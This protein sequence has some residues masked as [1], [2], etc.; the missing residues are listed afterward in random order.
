M[1]HHHAHRKFNREKA[2]RVA[3]MRG[4]ARSLILHGSITTTV[5]K[6]KELR[7]YVEKLVTVAKSGTLASR[8]TVATRLGER[9]QA[10]SKI[11]SDFAP[12][13]AKRAGGYTRITKLGR[14]GKRV[15]EFAKIEFVD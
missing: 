2:Q 5:A 12:R 15:A 13:Y 14:V 3:L 11:F 10:L 8:R 1:R 9:S 4:L 7:P 6:A